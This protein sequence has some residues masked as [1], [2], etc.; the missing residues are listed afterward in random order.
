MGSKGGGN[1]SDLEA[2]SVVKTADEGLEKDLDKKPTQLL[3]EIDA[4]TIQTF[5][6]FKQYM[7]KTCI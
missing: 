5:C 1:G 7:M 4:L 6:K 3:S 2:V